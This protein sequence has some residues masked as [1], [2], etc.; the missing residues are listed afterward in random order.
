MG[1]KITV[2]SWGKFW[3]QMIQRPKNP[4]AISEELGAKTWVS[5][6]GWPIP[7]LRDLPNSGIKPRSPALQADSLPTELSG[8]VVLDGEKLTAFPLR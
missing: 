2:C 3:T 5:W 4:T 6:S 7:S 1:L 8:N